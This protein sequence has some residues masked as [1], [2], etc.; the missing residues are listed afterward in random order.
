MYHFYCG[1]ILQGRVPLVIV[2]NHIDYDGQNP[3]FKLHYQN[4]QHDNKEGSNSLLSSSSMLLDTCTVQ[5]AREDL[6]LKP[7]DKY[8]YLLLFFPPND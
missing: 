2:I 8:A 4:N 7:G 3:S 1:R 6:N 5:W